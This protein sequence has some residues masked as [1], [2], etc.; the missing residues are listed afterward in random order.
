[1]RRRALSHWGWRKSPIYKL[2]ANQS[3]VIDIGIIEDSYDRKH[4]FGVLGVFDAHQEAEDS[5]YEL[6]PDDNKLDLDLLEALHG[7]KVT[8]EVEKYGFKKPFY[9]FDFLKAKGKQPQLA[10]LDYFVKNETGKPIYVCGFTYMKK[11]KG[12]WVAAI[13]DKDDMAVWRYDKSQVLKL[14]PDQTGAITIDT[15]DAQRD[16]EYMIAFLGIFNE[17]EQKMAEESTYELLAPENKVHLGPLVSVAGKTIAL[18]I[19]QYGLG[20][21]IVDYMVKPAHQIDFT[22]IAS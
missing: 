19:E 5:T 15:N 17:H 9:D 2:N 8:I 22:K 11:A 18:E 21:D 1:M 12:T 14:D 10:L 6:L 20:D 16:R 4:T 3:V 7:K 13:A